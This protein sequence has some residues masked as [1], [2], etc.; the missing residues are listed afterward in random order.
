MKE[1]IKR[2]ES[3][4]SNFGHS[5]RREKLIDRKGRKRSLKRL[6][7]TKGGKADEKSGISSITSSLSLTQIKKEKNPRILG[8]HIRVNQQKKG[9]DG[10]G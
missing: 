8:Q 2:T 7:R 9:E 6:D 10:R 5:H 4:I 1:Q 3:T